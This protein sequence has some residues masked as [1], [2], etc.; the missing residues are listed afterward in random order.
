MPNGIGCSNQMGYVA[1]EAARQWGQLWKPPPPHQEPQALPFAELP[2][3]PP[4]TSDLLWEMVRH[5]PRAE[6]QG[7]DAW[8]PDDL[9]ALPKEAFDDLADV[10]TKVGA[11]SKWPEG[12][13]GAIVALLPKKDDHGPLAQRPISLPPMVYKLWAAARGAILKEWFAR[14]GY[15]SAWGQGKRKGAD[16][17]ARMAAA[18]AELASAGGYDALAAYI[19]CEKCYDHISLRDLA[20]QG[21]LQGI[22]RSVSLA[23]AQYTGQ[24]YVRWAGAL[25]KPVDPTHGIPAGCP[26]DRHAPPILAPC[27]E[28]HYGPGPRNWAPHLCGR[29]EALRPG[30]AEEGGP[31]HRGRFRRRHK[32]APPHVDGS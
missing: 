13:S 6:A 31:R 3:M 32:R 29:L 30:T 20:F 8:S 4:F 14:E 19:G 22:N 16:T 26:S 18:Q 9:K 1:K 27:Y 5:I 15:A 28:E 17:A 10:L 2:H 25:W 24:R 12:L 7:L 23:A 21:C 11:E